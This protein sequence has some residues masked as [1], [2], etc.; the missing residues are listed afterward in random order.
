MFDFQACELEE[1]I[2]ESSTEEYYFLVN[3]FF[4]PEQAE[5][6]TQR[7]RSYFKEFTQ[8]KYHSKKT[9]LFQMLLTPAPLRLSMRTLFIEV[10]QEVAEMASEAAA[11]GLRGLLTTLLKT[12]TPCL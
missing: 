2:Y 5:L 9:K 3:M 11:K 12:K 7:S 6:I 10:L 4:P 1:Y 8:T